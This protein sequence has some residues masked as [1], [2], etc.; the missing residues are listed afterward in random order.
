MYMY[1]VIWWVIKYNYP[2]CILHIPKTIT[3]TNHLHTIFRYWFKLHKKHFHN[4]FKIK[5]ASSLLLCIIYITFNLIWLNRLSQM[6][7]LTLGTHY[8]LPL[9]LWGLGTLICYKLT[10]FSYAIIKHIET[11]IFNEF[12]KFWKMYFLI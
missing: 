7:K 2:W 4:P 8:M 1:C 11:V 12:E 9:D 10:I 3:L 5:W 6:N